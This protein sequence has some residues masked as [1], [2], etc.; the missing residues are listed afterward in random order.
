MAKSRFEYVRKFETLDSCLLNTWIVVRVDGKGFHK[1]SDRHE[2]TKPNDDRALNLMNDCAVQVLLAFNDIILAY[3]QSDEYS[4]VFKRKT[5]TYNRRSSKLASTVVSLFTSCYVFNWKKFFPATDLL[6]P[7]SFDSRVVLYPT[8]RNLK[9]YLCWRQADCH[10]NNLYNTCFWKLV[11]EAGLD[12]RQAEER[13]KV[14]DS[15]MKNEMLFSEFNT[16]YNDES[17]MHKKGTVVYREKAQS[18]EADESDTYVLK[19]R[20]GNLEVV[21]DHIDI[22]KETFWKA[23]P[24]IL[25]EQAVD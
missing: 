16:N 14:T 21:V 10:I 22:I 11:Q 4:F 5:Q 3:G 17:E 25:G 15:A 23:H 1:F 7:P 9:D 6:Y 20:G 8:T 12:N 19:K 13:L 2:F 24:S 18:K